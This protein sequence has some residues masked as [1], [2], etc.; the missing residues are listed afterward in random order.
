MLDFICK[1][2]AEL[3]GRE[4]SK[5][6]IYVSAGNRTSDQFK[7]TRQIRC[8]ITAILGRP[9]QSKTRPQPR[10]G[11]TKPTGHHIILT[12]YEAV[13]PK[14]DSENYSSSRMVNILIK[15]QTACIN[16]NILVQKPFVYISVDKL[17]FETNN[18]PLRGFIK[19]MMKCHL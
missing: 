13:H 16:S 12:K 1:V 3:K 9:Q 18:S 4:T 7:K 17:V 10:G 2:F 11:V 8:R 15:V 6:K 19:H 14:A 5:M